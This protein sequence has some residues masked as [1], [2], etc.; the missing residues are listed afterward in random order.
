MVRR[1]NAC[2]SLAAHLYAMAAT[3][4]PPIAAPDYVQVL[5]PQGRAIAIPRAEAERMAAEGRLGRAGNVD[6]ARAALGL[7]PAF[8]LRGD[9]V[10]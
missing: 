7:P 8:H 6:E 9:E 3:A 5:G 10:A 4:P 1:M 2:P